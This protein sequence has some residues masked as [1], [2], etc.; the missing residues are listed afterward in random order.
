[1][2]K[3]LTPCQKR[4]EDC[5]YLKIKNGVW[6]CEE[7]FGQLV[8][9]IDDCPEG[10]TLEEVEHAQAQG[11]EIK[12]VARASITKERKPRERK[13]DLEKEEIIQNL[14]NFLQNSA[15]NV[16]IT[17]KSKIIEFNVG[18]NHYKLDLIK[19]RTPKK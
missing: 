10:I 4:C 11:L 3:T 15:E 5:P 16:Q 8:N 7:C 13:P 17:N 19:Q 18:K 12:N 1:M 6:T 2:S 9:E 14:A